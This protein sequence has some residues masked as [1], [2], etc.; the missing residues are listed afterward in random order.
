MMTQYSKVSEAVKGPNKKPSSNHNNVV[1]RVV[2]SF[3]RIVLLQLFL[4]TTEAKVEVME[5]W[6]YVSST[7]SENECQI[8]ETLCDVPYS[9][10]LGNNLCNGGDYNTIECCYDEGDCIEFN[11][12]FAQFTEVS[13]Q[14]NKSA[15]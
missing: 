13:L 2:L 11:D 15:A 1:S 6:G 7:T 14:N 9:Y 5:G 8:D 4:V 3:M 10:G 12:K